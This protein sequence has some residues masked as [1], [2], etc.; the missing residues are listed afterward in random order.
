MLSSNQVAGIHNE[1]LKLC[2][3]FHGALDLILGL[4]VLDKVDDAVRV[5]KLVVV[6]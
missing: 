5:T 2:K 3:E 1:I 4:H 6:P